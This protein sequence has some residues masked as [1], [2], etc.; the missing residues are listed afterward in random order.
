MTYK[1][2]VVVT[3]FLP[4]GTDTHP[5]ALVLRFPTI[6]DLCFGYEENK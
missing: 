5:P 2:S 1:P 4:D 3:R 6:S